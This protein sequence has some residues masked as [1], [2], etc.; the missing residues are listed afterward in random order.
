MYQSYLTRLDNITLFLW[1]NLLIIL[2]IKLYLFLLF[3]INSLL[4]KLGGYINF[5]N[6]LNLGEYPHKGF[7]KKSVKYYSLENNNLN[8][9]PLF[10][11]GFVLFFFLLLKLTIKQKKNQL[12]VVST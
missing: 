8:L 9:N 3:L 4:Y 5:Y 6:L 7:I 12:K 10:V 11:T 2:K 1:D